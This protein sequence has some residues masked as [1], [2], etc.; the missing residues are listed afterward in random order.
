MRLPR[1]VLLV[2][3]A[4]VAVSGFWPRRPTHAPRPGPL[5][6]L[7]P[8][9][10]PESNAL[11]DLMR[12]A[13]AE[14]RQLLEQFGYAQAWNEPTPPA[15]FAAFRAWSE[16]FRQTPAADREA[17][18]AEGVALARTRREALQRVMVAD[19]RRALALAVPAVVRRDLPAVVAAELEVRLSGRG[20]LSLVATT[21][22]PD[23]PVAPVP[24]RR[25]VLLGGQTYTAHVYGRREPQTAL[26]GVALHGIAIDRELAL[27]ESPLRVL[28][29]E[30][31]PA[32]EAMAACPVS[33]QPVAPLA[34]GLGVNTAALTVAEVAGRVVELCDTAPDMLATYAR[35]LE[36]GEDGSVNVSAAG[37]SRAAE[38]PTAWTTGTKQVLVIRVDFSDVPGEP[39]SQQAAQSVMDTGVRPLFEDMSYGQTS[40]V[41]TVTPTVF[42]MPQT[43]SSYAI[44]DNEDQLHADARAAAGSSGFDR[45][46]VVFPNIGTGR[47][48]GSKITFGGEGLI[49]GANIWIN[50]SGSFTTATVAHE[51]GHTYG[52]LHS[53]L[54]RVTDA[55]PISPAGT[56]LEYGDP[57][58]TMGSTSVTNVTRDARHHFNAWHKNRLGWLP[59]AAVTTV[60]TSGTY[61]IYRF[62]SRNASRTQPQALRIF[63]DGVRWYWV[64]LRQN[65]ATGTP[66]ANSAYV[67]WGYNNRQQSQLL[68]LT[69]P[70]VTATDAALPIGS[71]FTDAAHGLSIKPIARGGDEPSQFLDVE[72]TVPAAPASVVAAWGREGAT[73]FSGNTGLPVTPEPETSVPLELTGVQAIAAGDQHV[74]ALKTDGSVVAW[75]NHGSGQTSVPA[76]LGDVVSVAAGVDVSGVVKRDG[77]VQLWGST[78]AAHITPPAGLTT[79]TRL[80]IGRNHALALKADGTVVA[81]GAN[82]LSQATVPTGLADVVSI[83]AGTEF[84]VALKR[85]GTLTTWGSTFGRPPAGTTGIAAI[86]ACGVFTGGQFVVALRTDGTVT[87]WGA[88][89]AGQTT[90][91]AGL[92]GVVAVA[93]G[94][95]HALA[96]KSD[97][98]VVSW[99]TGSATTVPRSLPRARAV[100]TSASASFA[101]IGTALSLSTQPRDQV[102]AVGETAT[103]RVVASGVGAV[104]YQW[105]KD[106]GAIAGAT[107]PTFTIA[108]ATAS[109]AGVYDVVVRDTQETVISTA[110]R[111]TVNPVVSAPVEVSRIANLSIRT[112]AGTGAQTLIVGFVVGGAGT[113]GTKPLLVRGVGPAL[114]GFGVTGALTNPKVELYSATSVK[115]QENDDWNATDAATFSRVGAFALP[116]GSRD[117][118]LYNGAMTSA[119]Y[120]AQLSGVG[121]TTGVVLAEIYDVTA[122]AAFDVSTPRLVN[123]S[124]R[125]LSGTGGDRL[126]A[127]FVIA[128][129]NRKRVLI[130]AIGPTL[131]VF[132]VTGVLTDPVLELYNAAALKVLENDNWGGTAE[133][134]TAF[135]AVGAFQLTTAS[136]DAAMVATLDPGSYTA[137]VAG[138]NGGTGVALIEIYE[139]P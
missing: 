33:D 74:V 125:A 43:A 12:A 30:E 42:R 4:V 122:G 65:F 32:G 132:G 14:R 91:P 39:I 111:L 51:L 1:V 81:W 97:G 52:L 36:A 129:P 99:G 59:D 2:V 18:V 118:A 16:R 24:V 58:D 60:A 131:T 28:E 6:V 25:R 31:I 73:F 75:G 88:N 22:A 78:T 50:G 66:Q 46:I 113:S 107:S 121:G 82:N 15:A 96:L 61:R 53:N 119:S 37:P 108:G 117:A 69:T 56:T 19:P 138:A 95:F 68:D 47:I 41:T 40:F 76:G 27:H 85:D 87:A 89:N 35:Q 57:F 11:A 103:F 80:S 139:V 8:G 98:S 128:G 84:S 137:Q 104:T 124:A 17:L 86:A 29:P 127:G 21:P 102:I 79:V 100:A 123:V 45:V 20:Q 90:V 7:V 126:I 54:W 55:N 38:A 48:P 23:E 106:G 34:A 10:A 133:L 5:P 105:R 112:R 26:A 13:A 63:S 67:V 94:A 71:T 135:A 120:S 101:V 110:G 9:E 109:A 93:A 116:V 70:G 72:V 44:A 3:L 134:T 136:R 83:L 77:T 62:D 64:G 130:R 115:L 92:S 49:N 114:A